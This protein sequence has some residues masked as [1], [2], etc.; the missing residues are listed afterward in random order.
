LAAQIGGGGGNRTRVRKTLA[1]RAYMRIRFVWFRK[2]ADQ[3]GKFATPLAL[4]SFGSD[5]R[6]VIRA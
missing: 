3:T 5:P 4:L 6:A 2:R 1:D